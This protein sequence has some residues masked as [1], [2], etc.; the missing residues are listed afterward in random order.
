MRDRPKEQNV[1]F[2]GTS[3][4]TKTRLDTRPPVADGWA[5]A[6]MRIFPLFDS[7]T[8][9]DWPTNQL[10]DSQGSSTV[11]TRYE[12]LKIKMFYVQGCILGLSVWKHARDSGNK[13]FEQ[14]INQSSCIISETTKGYSAIK[15]RS[16]N[17]DTS[18]RIYLFA[19]NLLSCW[20]R[21]NTIRIQE[22]TKHE[23]GISVTC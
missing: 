21:Y 10:M 11:P 17:R 2:K 15:K 14:A 22:N 12:C 6:D 1:A 4:V 3:I 20:V 13:C 8:S 9:T 16:L 5:G 18:K 23:D 7:I 19:L